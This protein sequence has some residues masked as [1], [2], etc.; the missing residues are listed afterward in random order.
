MHSRRGAALDTWAIVAFLRDEPSAPAVRKALEN[1]SAAS[2]INL[3]EVLYIET[4]RVGAKR[5]EIA[6]ESMA[7]AV[8][9]EVPDRHAIQAAARI[10]A[11]GGLSYADAFAIEIAERNGLPLLTGDP[12]ILALSRSRLRLGDLRDPDSVDAVLGS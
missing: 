9:A 4:R 5:A 6:V 7:A 3:G 8:D 1:G 2:W 10:K 11:G 12:E